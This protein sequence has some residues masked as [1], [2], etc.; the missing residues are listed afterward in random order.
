MQR[1][2]LLII[3]ILSTLSV[4]AFNPTWW[5]VGYTDTIAGGETLCYRL[6]INAVAS[7]GGYA[8]FWL[9]SNRYGD[10]SPSPYSGNLSAGL[11]KAAEHPHRWWD[12][13]AA[14]E[15]VGR[16]QSRLPQPSLYPDSLLTGYFRQLYAHVRIGCIDLTA[17][18]RPVA[19]LT[20]DETLSSGSLLLSN[21]A[22]PLPR[23]SIGIDEYT[24]VPGLYGYMEIKGGLTH[25]WLNDHQYVHHSMLHHAWAGARF[26]GALPVNIAYEFH[27]A[28]QWGGYSPVHGDLGNDWHAFLNTVLARA[29]GT[30][31]NDQ[32]NAQGNHLCSQ[33]LSL[34]AK[35]ADWRLTAYWQ[36][37]SEDNIRLLGFG[38]NI[39]DGI[40]GLHVRQTAWP[41]LSAFTYEFVNTTSQ[42]GPF[43]DRD[44]LCFA[45]SDQYY[46]NTVYRNGWNYMLRTMGTPLITAPLYNTNGQ[47]STMN[48]RIRAH[49][50][51]LK[52]DIY[53]WLW[54]TLITY[55][56][57][58]G[59]NN[60]RAEQLSHNTAWMVEVR[61]HFSKAWGIDVTVSLAGDAGDQWGNHLGALLSISKTGIITKW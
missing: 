2:T 53:G 51:G 61:K 30:M 42:S 52:G 41:Y 19:Y 20:E 59:N 33:Q 1:L 39:T 9:Q 24:P 6:G 28:A 10:L 48:S 57:N 49:H 47:L 27:H 5:P 54:R 60:T 8:P 37:M 16:V 3:S 12:W 17:G 31:L 7:G 45:G 22:H 46:Q 58:Y 34:I 25:A 26:G 32:L 40:W 44:G 35:G 56:R 13:D 23:L 4:W 21:N 15:I 38:Q 14:I 55:T 11:I 18:I 50:I 43:H 29:G 36:N